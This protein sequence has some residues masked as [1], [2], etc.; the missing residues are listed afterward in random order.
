MTREDRFQFLD[1]F[2]GYGD[3]AN[4][5]I[6]FVLIEEAGSLDP[7]DREPQADAYVERRR[8]KYLL[9]KDWE[10]E[11]QKDHSP[12]TIRL[13]SFAERILV[14][15]GI[16]KVSDIKRGN[17]YEANEYFAKFVFFSNLLPLPNPNLR[18][19]SEKNSEFLSPYE[20]RP[21]YRKKY[22][23]QKL[24]MGRIKALHELVVRNRQDPTMLFMCKSFL[25]FEDYKQISAICDKKTEASEKSFH[26]EN[27]TKSRQPPG[28]IFTYHPLARKSFD[29]L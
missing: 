20:S 19:W 2:L 26:Q 29:R 27:V 16:I 3:P 5:R 6:I 9:F 21:D 13:R 7:S 17:Y 10:K 1:Q 28:L 25:A 12:T 15:E 14:R 4:A 24:W 8:A 23:N 22:I 18:S 11:G